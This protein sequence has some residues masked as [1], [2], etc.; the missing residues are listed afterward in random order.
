M[1]DYP[2]GAETVM[3]DWLA[4]PSVIEAL[5]VQANGTGMQYVKTVGNLLPLYQQLIAKYRILIYSGDV[6]AC[7][8]Y[9][10]TEE[11]YLSSLVHYVS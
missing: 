4:I 7:V 6:D 9:I 11:V 8:P 5:H 10:G 1:N 2:C 3:S